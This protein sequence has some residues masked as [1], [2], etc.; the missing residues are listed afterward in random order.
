MALFREAKLNIK[1]VGL[2]KPI[3]LGLDTSLA[4]VSLSLSRRNRDEL[5]SKN[6][7]FEANPRAD[8]LESQ[9]ADSKPAVWWNLKY[10][11]RWLSDGSVVSGNPIYTNIL[12]NEIGRGADLD[13]LEIWLQENQ[14]IIKQLTTA[15]FSL[16]APK[17]IDF[18]SEEEINISSAQK[19]EVV[20]N[21]HCSRCHGTY[22]KNWSRPEA[23]RMSLREKLLTFE[24]KYPQLTKVKDVGTDPFRY[25]GMNSLTKLNELVISKKHQITIKP[26]KGYVPPPLVGIWARWPY[27][28]NNSVPSL[29]ALL[30]PASQRPKWFY[31]GPA[32]NSQT[33]FDKNCNGYPE[34]ERAPLSW[35]KN[36]EMM[37]DT[38]KRGLGNFGHEE[39]I[40]TEQGEEMLSR[41]EKMDLIRYLQTL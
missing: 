6:S 8:I 37:V 16:E 18:F 20:F 26:Q 39:G 40:I 1:S 38:T 10:K 41:E 11:N 12:W 13:K 5:A 31:Q 15:V 21:E 17:F 7:F 36:K 30:T 34:V 22:I 32:N 27:L 4:Q 33:D 29:C 24:V 28:H 2:K 23:D 19:G 3:N 35:K 9:P 25:L 14:Q